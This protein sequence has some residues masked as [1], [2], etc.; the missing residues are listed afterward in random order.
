[1]SVF[2]VFLVRTF[3]YSRENTNQKN[4]EYGHFSHSVL[5]LPISDQIGPNLDSQTTNQL[6]VAKL[7][8]LWNEN[9]FHATVLIIFCVHSTGLSIKMTNKTIASVLLMNTHDSYH[10]HEMMILL[11]IA[12][13]CNYSD[14]APDFGSPCLQH[15]FSEKYGNKWTQKCDF[16]S[17]SGTYVYLWHS[18]FFL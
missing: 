16:L 17:R 5:Q 7:N 18:T 15:F 9:D 4:S 8:S 12:R 10:K 3:R 6:I 14:D 1:M 13:G 2:W 11:S